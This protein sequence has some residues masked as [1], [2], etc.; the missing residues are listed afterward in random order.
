[1]CLEPNNVDEYGYLE[2]VSSVFNNNII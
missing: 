1:M 2:A